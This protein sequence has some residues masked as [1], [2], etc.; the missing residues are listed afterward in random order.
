MTN[1]QSTHELAKRL[2]NRKIILGVTALL[3]AIAFIFITSF[4]PFIITGEKLRSEKFW[5]D[6]LIIIAITIFAMVSVMYI[7]QA[8]N[9]QNPE[10][11]LAKAKVEFK[12]SASKI[13]NVNYF[14]QWVK[15]VKQPRDIQ[16]I[17]ERELRKIGIDDYTILQLEDAQI[18]ALGENAQRFDVPNGEK[19]RYYSQLQEQQVL[20]VLELKDG[21]KKLRLVE[22]GY[23]LTVSSIENDKTDSE[24]SGRE[25][26]KKTLKLLFS[27]ITKIL[28]T[29]IPALIFGA[30]AKDLTSDGVDKAQ[31]WATFLSRMLALITSAFM[32]YIVG[33]QMNDIDAD[34]ILLRVKVHNEF[35]QDDTFKPQTQQEVAKQEFVQRVKKENEEYGKSL[36]LNK[37]N[38]SKNSLTIVE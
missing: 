11:Q 6:E 15:K 3:I 28:I 2:L 23:Y 32:G 37:E 36:G 31:A 1:A 17:K 9:A 35:I 24:K 26:F 20:K 14:S 22:P 5:T 29:V 33:C 21:V 10:S 25:Q 18:K 4:V 38:H 8:G 7:G 19:G 16:A 30:L 13:S 34:Y 27:I 12:T